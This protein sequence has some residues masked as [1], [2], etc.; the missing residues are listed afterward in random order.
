LE[1]G[2][3]FFPGGGVTEWTITGFVEYQDRQRMTPGLA[4][5]RNGN[6]FPSP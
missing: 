1:N 5:R 3:G 4:I 6:H 2:E